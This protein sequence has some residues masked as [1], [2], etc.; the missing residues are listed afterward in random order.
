MTAAVASTSSAAGE[1]SFEPCGPSCP[2]RVISRSHPGQKYVNM[3]HRLHGFSRIKQEIAHRIARI[4]EHIS[5][6]LTITRDFFP[7]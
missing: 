1:L 4:K 3:V 6:K 7:P 2:L 5:R